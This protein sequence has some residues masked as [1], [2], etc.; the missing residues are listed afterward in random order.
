MA[1]T[2]TPMISTKAAGAKNTVQRATPEPVCRQMLLRRHH[3]ADKS[4]S[5]IPARTPQSSRDLNNQTFAAVL[6][7]FRRL[8]FKIRRKPSRRPGVT[9]QKQRLMSKI[10]AIQAELGLPSSYID[11]VARKICGVDMVG[12]CDAQGLHK[13]V[14]ALAYHQ[15]RERKRA[16]GAR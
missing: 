5:R 6:D 14:A 1:T 8:G 10:N 4:V 3:R 12:W 2:S 16:G 9:P 7:H 13:V 11:K 15:K